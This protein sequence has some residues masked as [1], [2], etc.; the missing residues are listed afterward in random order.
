MSA[1]EAGV[2]AAYSTTTNTPLSADSTSAT[3]DPNV[4]DLEK[5]GRLSEAQK[6]TESLE[7]EKSDAS[8]GPSPAAAL[9]PPPDGGIEAWTAVLGAF[10]GLFVSFGW[11]N[12]ERAHK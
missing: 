2:P 11:I 1:K 4:N 12:C 9:G 8:V 7:P 6:V 5:G 3:G 10:C